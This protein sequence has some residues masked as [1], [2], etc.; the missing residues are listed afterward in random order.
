MGNDAKILEAKSLQSKQESENRVEEIRE[1]LGRVANET[2]R[3]KLQGIEE[4][5]E[6]AVAKFKQKILEA[7]RNE[8]ELTRRKKQAIEHMY[9]ESMKA[10]TMA[11]EAMRKAALRTKM[12]AAETHIAE[13]VTQES[14]RAERSVQAKAAAEDM[15]EETMKEAEKKK[16]IAESKRED[17]IEAAAMSGE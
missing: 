3:V 17:A 1:E 6:K 12:V 15:G 2:T 7:T 10:K 4:Q 16:A 9:A 14:E 5:A 8:T 11:V 13:K